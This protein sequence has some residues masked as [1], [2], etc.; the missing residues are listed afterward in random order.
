M[1]NAELGED[2]IVL[3]IYIT[4]SPLPSLSPN[5]YEESRKNPCRFI[6]AAAV[7]VQQSNDRLGPE[8]G[9]ARF[10]KQR[11]ATPQLASVLH[12]W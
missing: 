12:R 2:I 6:F 9:V 7:K 3:C 10:E 1:D 4:L 5:C 11:T 8:G